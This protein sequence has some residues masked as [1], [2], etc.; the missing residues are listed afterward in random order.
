LL[1]RVDGL[2]VHAVVCAANIGTALEQAELTYVLTS[3]AL[4]EVTAYV[5]IF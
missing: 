1:T 5:A 4:Q 2:R 3:P